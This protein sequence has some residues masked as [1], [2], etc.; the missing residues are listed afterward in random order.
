M[1]HCKSMITANH[2]AA[3]RKQ[4]AFVA[5]DD[6]FI[7]SMLKALLEERG[8]E[9]RVATNGEEAVA[10]I[11]VELPQVL[12][13]DL[14]MPKAD[15]YYVLEYVRKH[16]HVFPIVIITNLSLEQME[17]KGKFAGVSDILIKSNLDEDEIWNRIEKFFRPSEITQ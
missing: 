9:V 15:G 11:S 5:E 13:L 4:L 10:L 8:V 1:L 7:A 2:P 12:L 14:L 6:S 17:T 3:E 16:N